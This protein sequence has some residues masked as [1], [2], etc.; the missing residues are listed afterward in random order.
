MRLFLRTLFFGLGIA[1]AAAA[2]NAPSTIP[3]RILVPIDES[4]LVTLKGNIH[5]LART[6]VDQGAAPGSLPTGRMRLVLQRSQA[7]QCALTQ[8]L[9]DLQNPGSPS[10]HKWLTPAQYGATF[11]VSESDLLRVE[12]WLESHGFKIEKVPAARNEIEFSGTVGQAAS[13]FH[14]AIDNFSASGEVHFANVGDPQIPA[15]L[16]PVIAGVG[17]L[18]DFHPKPMLVRGPV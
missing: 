10:Y 5:P 16:A 9:S 15:A 7:Q 2:Q 6:Q 17:P 11:G 4:K 14:T 12:G 13:T 3:D 8:Y 18:N 1:V